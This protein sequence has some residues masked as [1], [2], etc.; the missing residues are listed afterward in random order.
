[1]CFLIVLIGLFHSSMN[2]FLSKK[3]DQFLGNNMQLYY[4]NKKFGLINNFK[5]LCFT[6][7]MHNYLSMIMCLFG[8]RN[9]CE[10]AKI[11]AWT[12]MK[13]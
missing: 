6:L 11:S 13:I 2:C 12:L 4:I 5:M 8:Y 9:F 1:M 10:Q 3:N 7:C